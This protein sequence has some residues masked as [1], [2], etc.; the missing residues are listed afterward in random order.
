MFKNSP[1]LQG[2]EFFPLRSK[3][4]ARDVR[5]FEEFYE[6]LEYIRGARR[7]ATA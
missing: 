3:I 4:S 1:R 6:G 5:V 7:N 2:N